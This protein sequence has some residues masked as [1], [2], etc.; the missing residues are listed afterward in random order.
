MVI[1]LKQIFDIVGEK[2][3]VNYDIPL[4]QLDDYSGYAFSSPISVKGLF[5]NRAGVVTL[6]FTTEFSMKLVCDRC[7]CDFEPVYNYSFN[8]DLIRNPNTDN[9]EY[10]ICEDSKLD[11]NELAVSDI[12]LQLPSKTLCKDDCL[13]LCHICGCD[14]NTKE[15]DCE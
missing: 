12:I 6:K 11:L 4:T 15:C 8:H 1:G 2:L 3:E 10:V 9:D 14:R 5:E 13:G 7:L